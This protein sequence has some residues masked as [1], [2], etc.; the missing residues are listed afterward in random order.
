MCRCVNKQSAQRKTTSLPQ[1]IQCV[2]IMCD[3]FSLHCCLK[4]RNNAKRNSIIKSHAMQP[5]TL[6][7]LGWSVQCKI[8]LD[9][10]YNLGPLKSPDHFSFCSRQHNVK[11]RSSQSCQRSNQAHWKHEASS[12]FNI[13]TAVLCHIR[14]NS[15]ELFLADTIVQ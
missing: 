5:E 10:N 4:Y 15:V 13:N 6:E 2:F 11:R 9:Y 1:A 8:S 12:H 3:H 7:A 14:C